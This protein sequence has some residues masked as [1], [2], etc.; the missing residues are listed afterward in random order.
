MNRFCVSCKVVNGVVL[1]CCEI[2]NEKYGL[3]GV[4]MMFV[5]CFVVVVEI[6]L[7]I[8]LW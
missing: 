7:L 4:F 3:F 1:F 8:L 2:E 5:R 6:C